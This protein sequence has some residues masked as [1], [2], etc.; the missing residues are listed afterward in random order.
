MNRPV[1]LEEFDTA[2]AVESARVELQKSL[3]QAY[4]TARRALDLPE[5]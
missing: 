5:P 2:A 1:L 4:R 3:D